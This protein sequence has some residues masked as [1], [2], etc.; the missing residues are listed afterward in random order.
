VVVLGLTLYSQSA[1]DPATPPSIFDKAQLVLI[2]AGIAVDALALVAIFG[3]ASDRYGFTANRTAALGENILLLAN[4]AYAAVLL[5]RFLR[6][7][8]GFAALERWQTTYLPVYAIWAW[9]VVLAFP[10]LFHFA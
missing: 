2:L 7:R 3:H 10:P 9:I 4:L 8:T 1:R 6:R 5:G